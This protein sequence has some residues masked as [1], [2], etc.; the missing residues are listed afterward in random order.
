MWLAS[1]CAIVLSFA[2]V[3]V[4][5]N[6]YNNSYNLFILPTAPGPINNYVADL[7]WTLGSTQKIQ[8]STTVNSY[9]IALFQQGFH[10]VPGTPKLQTIY[11]NLGELENIP[12]LVFANVASRR[13]KRWDWAA[14]FR[15]AGPDLQFEPKPLAC[16]LPMAQP[17]H[18]TRVHLSLFQHH[19]PGSKLVKLKF[20]DRLYIID[21]LDNQHDRKFIF[22]YASPKELRYCLC[23]SFQCQL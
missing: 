14:I 12:T 6:S 19:Q 8:W 15:L 5:D 21:F 13:R 1:L 20:V 2:R 7:S 11:S 23:V 18:S 9:Y 22:E 3:N 4:G 10:P 16:L 17:V